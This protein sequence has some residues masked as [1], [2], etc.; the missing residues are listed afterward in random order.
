MAT[1][2]NGYEVISD[3]G[4]PRLAPLLANGKP[5]QPRLGVLKGDV[6]YIMNTLANWLDANIEPL[7]T[8]QSWSFTPKT[9]T[10][11][12]GWSCHASAT[13]FD[14]NAQKHGQGAKGTWTADQVKRIDTY[15]R[16]TLDGLV[17][18]GEHYSAPT[19][20]DGMHF[21]WRGSVLSASVLARKL[22]EIN[23][24]STP[25][26]PEQ[27]KEWFDMASKEEV[28]KYLVPLVADEVINRMVPL[29][30]SEGISGAGDTGRLADA[31]S[32][33]I[34]D[35]VAERLGKA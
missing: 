30:R 4:D 21:E 10:G 26:T 20:T 17:R 19:K 11:G 9:V 31:I 33:R 2:Y 14:Y 6:A 16:D 3:Y 8:K 27:S 34:A 22:Q 13:A 5:F 1:S 24:P 28:A 35:A 18:W 25:P 12:S 32:G 29:F 7:D 15:L 23:T